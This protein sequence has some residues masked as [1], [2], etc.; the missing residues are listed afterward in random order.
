M[1]LSFDCRG[2]FK[3]TAWSR[4]MQQNANTKI[5]LQTSLSVT[6]AQLGMWR[7]HVVFLSVIYVSVD[8]VQCVSLF[9]YCRLCM[10]VTSPL[11]GAFLKSSTF[12]GCSL[13][14]HPGHLCV[15]EHVSYFHLLAPRFQH[16]QAPEVSGADMVSLY[17]TWQKNVPRAIKMQ[18]EKE[19][20]S[21]P[22]MFLC[23]LFVHVFA[24]L[25]SL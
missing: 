4:L 20:P 19:R 21:V 13:T 23:G 5:T 22:S 18:F 25:K 1:S 10:K 12:Q 24:L 16:W 8:V 14:S 9:V 3:H 11:E 2:R 6:Y 7:R 17:H 15:C